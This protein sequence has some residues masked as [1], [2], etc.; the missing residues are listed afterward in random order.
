[1]IVNALI[2]A[3]SHIGVAWR[4]KNEIPNSHILDQYRN[5][6]NP[7]AHYDSTAEEILTQ[8]DG[9]YHWNHSLLTH[10]HILLPLLL[11]FIFLLLFLTLLILFPLLL[12]SIL[13]LLSSSST[14]TGKLDMVVLGAGTGGTVTGVGRKLKEKLP[15]I[16]VC[17]LS[18]SSGF[19]PSSSYTST[20]TT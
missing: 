4:L 20:S 11:L 2:C 3:E 1:M 5:P 8:C 7:L 12:L 9:E 6:S 17:Y 16:K 19:L 14:S 10:T 18:S 15:D 13:L